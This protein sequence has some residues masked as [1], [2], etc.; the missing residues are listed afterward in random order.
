MQDGAHARAR[1][2]W[3]GAW[4]GASLTAGRENTTRQRRGTQEFFF[5]LPPT[6]HFWSLHSGIVAD[7][8]RRARIIR[9]RP[10]A[11][12]ATSGLWKKMR[13]LGLRWR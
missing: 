13:I 12:K 1:E 9:L 5:H 10:L 2:F 3:Q 4:P 11:P 8:R 6:L 7:W